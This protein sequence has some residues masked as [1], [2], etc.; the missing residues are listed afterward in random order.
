MKEGKAYGI[1]HYEGP[2]NNIVNEIPLIRRLANLPLELSVKVSEISDFSTEDS[3]LN[4]IVNQS[5]IYGLNHV[6][7]ANIP[8]FSN[9]EAS[10]IVGDI[11]NLLY[12]SLYNK[13]DPFL[14]SIIY[15]RGEHYV[16][17]RN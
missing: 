5:K 9:R 11:F 14:V 8:N 12:I 7:E 17:R 13:G 3:A 6:L 1:F 15:K 4:Q 16:Q 2:T 10:M